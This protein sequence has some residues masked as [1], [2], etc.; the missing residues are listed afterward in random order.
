MSD[1]MPPNRQVGRSV[2][3]RQR[4]L[5]FVLAE[6]DLTGFGGRA[7]GIRVEGFGNGDEADGGGIASS[8]VGCARD[9]FAYLSQPRSK[10]RGVDHYFLSVATMPLAV[11]AFGPSGASFRY[12][13]NS[14]PA[15]ARLPSFTSAMPS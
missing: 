5:D 12:V 9:A 4:F 6:I 8:P 10:R 2:H 13:S 14:V 15:A 3:L 11:A 1:E 7:H